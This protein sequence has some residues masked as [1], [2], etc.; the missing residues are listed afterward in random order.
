CH[1]TERFRSTSRAKCFGGDQQPG[2]GGCHGGIP[3]SNVV[4]CAGVRSHARWPVL[5]C[6]AIWN[7]RFSWRVVRVFPEQCA[8][9]E[10]LVRKLLWSCE[11]GGTPARLRRC[12]RRSAPPGPHILFFLL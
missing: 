8:R 3:R 6:D 1:G 4:V 9:R 10:G 5:D 2:V 11:T 7:E 12:A